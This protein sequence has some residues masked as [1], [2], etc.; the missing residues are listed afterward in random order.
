MLFVL[1]LVRLLLKLLPSCFNCLFYVEMGC[2]LDG[3]L[4]V[5]F[6]IVFGMIC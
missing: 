2:Y 3:C 1:Q 6:F 5:W 4:K